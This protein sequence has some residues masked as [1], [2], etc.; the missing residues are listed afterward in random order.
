M[1]L[2]EPS[3]MLPILDLLRFLATSITFTVN[4]RAVAVFLD[5]HH[6]GHIQKS[7]EPPRT[8][9]VREEM[10]RSSP[11]NIMHVKEVQCHRECAYVIYIHPQPDCCNQL[12][13]TIEAEVMNA[14]YAGSGAT[15]QS[16]MEISNSR[17][18]LTMFTAEVDV[19]L[20]EKILR[21]LYRCMKKHPPSR[22]KYSLIYVGCCTNCTFQAH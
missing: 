16:S 21:E 19:T 5:D 3:P 7:L 2:R 9:S 1:P 17:V 20:D 14:V 22:L 6:V 11:K 12:G 18:D 13:I 4:L 8:I 10:K 15:N